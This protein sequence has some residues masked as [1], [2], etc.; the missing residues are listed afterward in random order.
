L[1]RLVFETSIRKIRRGP[2]TFEAIFRYP[3]DGLVQ[4]GEESLD[5]CQRMV[6]FTFIHNPRTR[7]Y[8]HR[9][10]YVC[11]IAD[12]KFFAY[13]LAMCKFVPDCCVGFR[14]QMLF[15]NALSHQ[16]RANLEINLS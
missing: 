16:L 2:L 8:R 10:F 5:L 4:V 6:G 3:P 7:V 9:Q 1:L 13:A 14:T 12:I 15:L 11:Y